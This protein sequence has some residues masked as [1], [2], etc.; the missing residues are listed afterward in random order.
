MDNEHWNTHRG[1]T[2]PPNTKLGDNWWNTTTAMMY[3]KSEHD[4]W[5]AVDFE[6][7]VIDVYCENTA[8]RNYE[9]AMKM[10]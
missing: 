7:H 6:G 4:R 2:P 9:R 10:L 3:Y 8:E 5:V 1:P